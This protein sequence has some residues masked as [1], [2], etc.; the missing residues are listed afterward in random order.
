MVSKIYKLNNKILEDYTCILKNEIGALIL[1]VVLGITFFIH[2]FVK[3]QGGI[4]NHSR[5]V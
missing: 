1:R 3:F 2:G 5:M 4:E